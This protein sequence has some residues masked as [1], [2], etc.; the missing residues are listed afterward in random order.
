MKRVKFDEMDSTSISALK[1]RKK[2]ESLDVTFRGSGN[3][4]RYFDV[5]KGDYEKVLKDESLGEAFNVYIKPNHGFIQL[6]DK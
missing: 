6:E 3:T 4:Y 5:C 2:P 1:Y